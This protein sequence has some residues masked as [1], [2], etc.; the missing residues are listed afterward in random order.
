YVSN[1]YNENDYLYI[2]E[3]NGQF[4]ES[5]RDA[6]GHT[7]LYSMGCDAA[8]LNND[9]LMD[10]L[11]L[12]M[13]PERNERVKL[14]AGD[15]NYDKYEQLLRAGF[16]H[17]TMRNMVQINLGARSE[18]RGVRSK[19]PS[20]AEIG[21][22]AGV[23][24]TDW[25][26]AGLLADFDND[27]W[28]DMFITNGYARDYTNME[29]L[30]FTMDEQLNRQQTGTQADE[31]TVIG[32]M[33]AINEPNYMFRNRGLTNGAWSMSFENQTAAWGFDHPTQSNGAAYADLDNDGDLDLVVNN[34]NQ[35]AF[36]YQNE[37]NRS[38]GPSERKH[39]YLA[40]SLTGNAP[41]TQGLGA[42]VMVYQKG[43]EQFVEQMPR[44]AFDR[45]T[46]IPPTVAIEQRITRG[47]RKSTVAT[48]TEVAQYLRLLYA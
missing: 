25:S 10:L 34:T 9:G 18:E 22:L 36:V 13:L 42:K 5:V 14:T 23:S 6:M 11:T 2:N 17:Q 8:D 32:K 44:P 15:D 41:N 21:Q 19:N 26:W 4:R 31:M 37:A 27:G 46:G 7:S 39:H 48:I 12:D 43:R 30:K 35:A 45:L 47:S 29:F 28:R 16:H 40:V 24:N 20:F 1:D 3:Q 38:D 33:P